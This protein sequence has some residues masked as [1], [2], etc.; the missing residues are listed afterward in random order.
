[1]L[2][3]SIF[4]ITGQLLKL[5]SSIALMPFL[6]KFLGLHQFGLLSW[7]TAIL[8]TVQIAEGGLSAGLLFFLSEKNS[9]GKQI[10]NQNQ[11]LTSGLILLTGS[12][13]LVVVSL[14]IIS[15][16]L[17]NTLVK[18]NLHQ[19]NDIQ[20]ALLLGSVLVAI[21]IL[22]SLFWAIYQSN[23]QYKTYNI[24][25][26][27][28]IV[29]NNIGWIF[30]AYFGQKDL[31]NFIILSIIISMFISAI[32][33]GHLSKQFSSFKWIYS[34]EI[35]NSMLKY[36]IGVWGSNLGSILYSQ[37]DKLIVARTLG[38]E[39]LGIYVIFT[40]VVSQLNTFTAQAVHPIIPLLRSISKHSI[41]SHKNISFTVR[42][43]FLLNIYI[44]LGGA[45][46]F[47]IFG[48]DILSFFLGDKYLELYLFPFRLISFIYGIYTLS[49]T[50]YFINLGIGKS[51]KVMIISILCGVLT[52]LVMYSSKTLTEVVM[53][54]T[55]FIFMLVLL[56]HGMKAISIDFGQWISMIIVP[57]L[58][59]L[60]AMLVT[61][62]S[63]F[64]PIWKIPI[65]FFFSMAM[66]LSFI[67]KFSNI[68]E[69]KFNYHALTKLLFKNE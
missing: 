42:K 58:L 44:S 48:S 33:F 34:S 10:G 43:L 67:K 40:N 4:N 16:L 36:N 14:S 45:G 52:L 28:Q 35:M 27:A 38:V 24:V 53:A 54:N 2:K 13:L 55:F 26:T 63:D 59:L 65:G 46:I 29:F 66:F 41:K 21:R 30:L 25:S 47:I 68:Y 56:F 3:N 69:I 1:M 9:A 51:N 17:V 19:K 8:S 12:T 18:I 32:A 31:T 50:G 39:L 61:G 5:I 62:L 20:N 57:L 64:T 22:Q 23:Q 37:G 11:I 60:G 15:P 7:T 49:V 6:V